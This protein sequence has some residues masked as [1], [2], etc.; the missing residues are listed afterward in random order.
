MVA[1]SSRDGS[2]S[3]RSRS[4]ALLRPPRWGG[5]WEG[6]TRISPGSIPRTATVARACSCSPGQIEAAIEEGA[7][8]YDF[9]LGDEEYKSRFANAVREVE[10]EILGGS[11]GVGTSSLLGSKGRS[12]ASVASFRRRP[13]RVFTPQSREVQHPLPRG[14]YR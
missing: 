7:A 5:G 1:R 12:G 2:A 14:R 8:E 6:A 11:A 13:E 3:G 4:T 9:L 10:T